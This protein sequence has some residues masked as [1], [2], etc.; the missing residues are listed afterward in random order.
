MDTKVTESRAHQVPPPQTC[1]AA[2]AVFA[3]KTPSV[4]S[5]PT[6]R[7][8]VYASL[9]LRELES[10]SMGAL[11]LHSIH[12]IVFVVKTVELVRRMELQQLANVPRELNCLCVRNPSIIVLQILVPT[13][14]TAQTTNLTSLVN[15]L[16]VS[17][18]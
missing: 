6:I 12:V 7:R 10:V 16:K 4:I 5:F 1:N 8:S 17:Q 14:E 18:E 2:I 15:V 3:M 11:P 13:M 9:V